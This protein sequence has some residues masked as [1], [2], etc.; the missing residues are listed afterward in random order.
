VSRHGRRCTER[1]RGFAAVFLLLMAAAT[2]AVLYMIRPLGSALFVAAVLAGVLWPLHLRLT[3]KVRGHRSLSAAILVTA[4]VVLLVGPL[5]AFSAFA[6]KEGVEG[7]RFVSETIRSDG[8]RAWW[9]SC[10]T[11][12]SVWC[13]RCWRG[14][15][16][17]PRSVWSRPSRSS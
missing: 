12:S 5:V 1:R 2:V 11:R 10:L 8:S 7:V 3:Q 9:R 14:C 17:G 15:R 13:E 6:I 16:A 4:V